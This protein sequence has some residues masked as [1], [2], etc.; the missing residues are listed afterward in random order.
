MWKAPGAVI[1]VTRV[2]FTV[3]EEPGQRGR[4][5]PPFVSVVSDKRNRTGPEL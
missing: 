3:C 4:S 5:E 1:K 2:V